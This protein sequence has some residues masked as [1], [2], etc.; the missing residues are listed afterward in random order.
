MSKPWESPGFSRGG[1]VNDSVDWNL[2]AKCLVARA[3][4]THAKKWPSPK[5][6]PARA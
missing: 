3:G 6:S 2:A 1:A 5:H 4:A